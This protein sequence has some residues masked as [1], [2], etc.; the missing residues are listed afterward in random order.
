MLDRARLC[1]ASAILPRIG[2]ITSGMA[3]GTAIHLFLERCNKFGREEALAAFVDPEMQAVCEAI[4]L[5]G[6]P[7][8]PRAYAAEVAFAWDPMTGAAREIGRGLDRDYSGATP[9][10]TIVGT[11]DVI[12][13]VGDDAVGV[14]DWKSEHDEVPPPE[15]NLQLRF[16]ALAA[17]RAYGRD[18]AIVEIIR[19]RADR[20][21]WRERAELDMFALAE[22]AE[23]LRELV[24]AAERS[25]AD[26]PQLVV[27]GHCR[28]CPSSRMC[29]AQ[30]TLVRAFSGEDTSTLIASYERQVT[31]ET[32]P[33][34]MERIKAMR[35][36]LDKIEAC[37]EG[38]AWQ[39]P[40]TFPDGKVWGPVVRKY[41]SYDAAKLW[42]V[43]A[44]KHGADAAWAAV[45]IDA[46]K[47]RLTD[48][49]RPIAAKAKAKISHLEKDVVEELAGRGGLKVRVQE[50]LRREFP[51]E[52]P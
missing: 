16:Y 43:V 31:V 1:P 27:G 24:R 10:E 12:A 11:A 50:E 3:R 25:R 37:C 4:D 35:G 26:V 20:P 5:E 30:I 40:V 52:Q 13:L 23:E 45:K 42:Q 19:P 39:T 33:N 14:F 15:K 9:G 22:V 34:V 7:L 8:D 47:K 32:V 44:D 17:A 28:R 36:A 29:P 38:I 49:L 6:L 51:K 18:R 21:A 48:A 2:E 41:E 46:P